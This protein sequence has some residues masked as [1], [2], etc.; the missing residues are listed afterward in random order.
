MAQQDI[1]MFGGLNPD[2]ISRQQDAE[3]MSTIRGASTP[4]KIG[5]IATRGFR[6]I[7]SGLG[8]EDPR[9]QRAKLVKEAVE[10][11]KSRATPGD[12]T[13]MYKALSEEFQKRGLTEEAMK[14]SMAAR[15][16][17]R[18]D[19]TDKYAENTDARAQAQEADRAD[20][21]NYARGRRKFDEDLK[22]FDL[23]QKQ[24]MLNNLRSA[25]AELN[26]QRKAIANIPGYYGKKAQMDLDAKQAEINYRKGQLAESIRHNKASEGLQ[27][28]QNK[29]AA[30]DRTA[31]LTL[32]Q[33]RVGF[34]KARLE[35][36]KW[37]V[38]GEKDIMGQVS[39]YTFVSKEISA[40]EKPRVLH[41]DV[42][43]G[44]MTEVGS[45]NN[46]YGTQ[47]PPG[48]GSLSGNGVDLSNPLAGV[49]AE[50]ARR[51]AERK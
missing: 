32:E 37:T 6:N 18:E 42:K 49:A 48:A 8:M 21:A 11:A 19:K 44:Q 47:P 23:D 30:A 4:D 2:D 51:A 20:T 38:Q 25:E 36:D 12:M 34:E 41:Y 5:L 50:K 13:G 35:R 22:Q 43:T 39:G 45:A 15:Q 29:Q 14:A 46:L 10:A 40:G 24:Q 3:Y 7:A 26:K 9:M 17:G 16:L 31:R 28:E 1:G 27:A 33:E